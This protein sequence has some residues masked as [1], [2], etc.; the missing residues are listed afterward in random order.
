M[1]QLFI[2]NVCMEIDAGILLC[3]LMCSKKKSGYM[4][5]VSRSVSRSVSKGGTAA[6]L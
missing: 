6:L 3:L 1:F 4:I 2:V 5:Y